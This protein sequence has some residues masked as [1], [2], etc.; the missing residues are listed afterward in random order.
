MTAEPP[1]AAERLD[2]DLAAARLAHE[3]I[4]DLH[5][6]LIEA[7]RYDDAARSAMDRAARVATVEI[8]ALLSEAR[9]LRML[10]EEQALLD[11]PAAVEGARRLEE[12]LARVEPELRRLRG[13]QDQIAR[14]FQA[15]AEEGG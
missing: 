15:L 5:D 7:G 9:R 2:L 12:E 3:T 6:A 4:W 8:P 11:P 10:W 1:E 14:R 13:L